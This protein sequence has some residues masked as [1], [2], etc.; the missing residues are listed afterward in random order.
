MAVGG[1][2]LLATKPY[3][4]VTKQMAKVKTTGNN[5]DIP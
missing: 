4:S 5:E 2:A 3:R 1:L